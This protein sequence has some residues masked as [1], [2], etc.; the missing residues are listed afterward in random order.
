MANKRFWLGMLAMALVFGITVVG[1]DNGST[2]GNDGTS[3]FLGDTLELSGQVYRARWNAKTFSVDYLPY[4]GPN[5]TLDDWR[6]GRWSIKNGNLSFSIGVPEG[7]QP[8]N[9]FK[10]FFW[11]YHDLTISRPSVEGRILTGLVDDDEVDGDYIR[12]YELR[13]ERETYSLGNG[14]YSYKHERVYYFYVESDTTLSGKGRTETQT[15]YWPA[16]EHPVA[17]TTKDF[18]LQLKTGW[19]AVYIKWE[20]Q[21]KFTGDDVNN[22]TSITNATDT[23]TISLGNPSLRWVLYEN[24]D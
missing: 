11:G 6:D 5:L 7:L 13:K 22:P 20:Y 17:V 4:A 19:N 1:C 21:L 23:G 16:R 9:D 10:D 3:P 15:G 24:I 2:N 14:S 12:R 8:V 18:T